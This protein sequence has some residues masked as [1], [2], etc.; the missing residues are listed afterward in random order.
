MVL[1][2][3]N[4]LSWETTRIPR[5]QGSEGKVAVLLGAWGLAAPSPRGYS[6]LQT[7]SVCP[8][9]NGP[10]ILVPIKW[11]FQIKTQNEN[12]ELPDL[13]N[14]GT[15]ALSRTCQQPGLEE[16][17]CCC[18]VA[19]HTHPKHPKS[20]THHS[21]RLESGC[22]TGPQLGLSPTGRLRQPGR[23]GGFPADVVCWRRAAQPRLGAATFMVLPPL[24][25]AACC[26][27]I[28][29]WQPQPG[30]RWWGLSLAYLHILSLGKEI[31]TTVTWFSG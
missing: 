6:V 21:S 13:L 16:G 4:R 17:S 18:G 24:L 1:W 25:L 15:R 26:P 14:S 8:Q 23:N 30:D 10:E 3:F 12:V 31:N 2:S 29:C 5:R 11:H 9:G 19:Q 20:A 22:Q 7:R 27:L 28:A